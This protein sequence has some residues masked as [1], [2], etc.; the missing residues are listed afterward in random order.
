LEETLA[1]LRLE[2]R[3]EEIDE[4]CESVPDTAVRQNPS[5]LTLLIRLDMETGKRDRALARYARLASVL[6]GTAFS[7]ARQ[8]A[9]LMLLAMAGRERAVVDMLGSQ[10]VDF[11][12]ESKQFWLATRYAQSRGRLEELS[13]SR[14]TPRTHVVSPASACTLACAARSPLCMQLLDGTS[15]TSR[16]TFLHGSCAQRPIATWAIRR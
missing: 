15:T 12:P 4:L 8:M 13:P 11:A 1:L 7:Y 10:F 9:R 16:A 3:Y 2:G 6:D 14:R 5:L